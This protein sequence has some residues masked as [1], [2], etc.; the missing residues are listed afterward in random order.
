MYV[1][2]TLLAM[3]ALIPLQRQQQKKTFVYHS[4]LS[5]MLHWAPWLRR[6]A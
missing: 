6:L 3:L 1:M 4:G 5:S 2:L